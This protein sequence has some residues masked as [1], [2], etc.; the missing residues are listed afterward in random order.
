MATSV[1]ITFIICGTILVL[2]LI[3]TTIPPGRH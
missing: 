2:A 1:Q 3:G